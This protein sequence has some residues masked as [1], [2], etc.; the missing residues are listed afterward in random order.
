MR[1]NKNAMWIVIVVVIVLIGIWLFVR[2]SDTGTP[3]AV[4]QDQSVDQ[5]ALT[6]SEDLSDGSIDAPA[7]GVAAASIAYADALVKYANERI[8]LGTRQLCT[9]TPDSVM[10]TNNTVIMIDNRAPV[11]RTLHIGGMYSV[12]AY[13]FKLIKLSSAT[14]TITWL[15]DCNSQQNVATI[16]LQK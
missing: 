5:Q 11:A 6:P 8:Q 1:K 9:A 10:Y 14:L 7:P 13:G 15:K 2:S 16:L 4:S 3:A 12:K